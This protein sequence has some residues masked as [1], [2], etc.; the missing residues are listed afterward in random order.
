MRG[1]DTCI[2]LGSVVVLGGFDVGWTKI[3]GPTSMEPTGQPLI[4][5]FVKH[6]QPHLPNLG[7]YMSAGRM[8]L[9]FTCLCL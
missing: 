5:Y 3:N 9:P 2:L 1:G 8:V 7:P 6:L 4:Y